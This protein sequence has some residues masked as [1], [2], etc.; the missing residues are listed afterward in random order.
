MKKIALLFIASSFTAICQNNKL[1]GIYVQYKE[2]LLNGED[3]SR[4]TYNQ[5]PFDHDRQIFFYA[6]KQIMTINNNG[7]KS[8]HSYTINKDLLTTKILL[9]K[10]N[11]TDTIYANY[12]YTLKNDTL[13][14]KEFVKGLSDQYYLKIYYLYLKKEDARLEIAN[15]KNNDVYLICD[16]YASFPGGVEEFRK[17]VQNELQLPKYLNEKKTKEKVYINLTIDETGKITDCNYI[18]YPRL[19]FAAEAMKLIRKM[20]DWTPAK[21][22]GKNVASYFKLPIIFN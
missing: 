18:G 2:T 22:K 15:N 17:F 13:I 20:P 14:L 10:E 5:K 9:E 7:I 3:G 1:S 16:E 6:D 21:I 19:I 11:K 8:N 4:Y 12:K